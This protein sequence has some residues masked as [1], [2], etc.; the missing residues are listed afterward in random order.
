MAFGIPEPLARPLVVLVAVVE[1][2]VGAALLA[3]A[4]SRLAGAVA[5]GLLVLFTLVVGVSFVRGRRPECSCRD[6]DGCEHGPDAFVFGDP[7]TGQALRTFRRGWCAAVLR[8]HGVKPV[9]V[10]KT[11]GD[12][13]IRTGRLTPECRAAF[14]NINLHFHDL[15]REAA[16]RWLDSGVV[17]LSTIQAWLGHANIS[18]TST[19]L[20]CQLV[21]QNNLMRRFEEQQTKAAKLPRVAPSAR[22][23]ESKGRRSVTVN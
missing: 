22:A 5:L 1:L 12:R 4:S 11:K 21:G 17:P 13:T 8:A 7:A 10:V 14:A 9:Y 23:A 19:Y 16:S 6:A 18:Q 20:Q 15:R 3:E 2:G